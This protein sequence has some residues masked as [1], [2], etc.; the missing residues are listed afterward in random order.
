M[1]EK[2]KKAKVPLKEVSILL[3]EDNKKDIQIITDY[4]NQSR[5]LNA[6]IQTVDSIKKAKTIMF[7]QDIDILILR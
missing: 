4:I 3:V 1:T 2:N 6:E 5:R 7:Y